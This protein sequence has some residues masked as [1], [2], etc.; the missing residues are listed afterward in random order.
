M[1]IPRSMEDVVETVAACRCHDVPVLGRG[2]ASSLAG[3]TCKVA[4][5]IDFSKYPNSI[6]W[7]D[8]ERRSAYVEPGVICDQ[9]RGAARPYGL[10]F[11]PDPGMHAYC[12][13]LGF[14][15]GP[16]LSATDACS[17]RVVSP[18]PQADRRGTP[19][20]IHSHGGSRV[21]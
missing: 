12:V 5:V 21:P 4:V 3:Q 8:P 14:V 13:S 2:A 18:G 10:T 11:G 7:L 1:V 19:A 15:T 9:L 17:C 6:H 16:L 20:P